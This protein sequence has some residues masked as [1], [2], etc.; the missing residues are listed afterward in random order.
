MIVTIYSKPFCVQ[1]K[2]T[3]RALEKKHIAYNVVDISQDLQALSYVEKLGYRQVPVVVA[4]DTHWAGFQPDK[5]NR[6]G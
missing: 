3:Y 4:G 1:C 5:L 6:L 2:A